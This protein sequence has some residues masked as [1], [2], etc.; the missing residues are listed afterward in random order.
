MFVTYDPRDGSEPRTW[1]F[2]PDEIT[3][4]Q[5]EAIETAMGL[6]GNSPVSF[7]VW[8]S[9]VQ[10][11]N[12][13]ARTVLLWH[14]FRLEHQSLAFKDMPDFVRKQL[15]VEM[16]VAELRALRDQIAKTKMDGQTKEIFEAQ[17]ERD[18]RDAM[19]RETGVIDVDLDQI[20]APGKAN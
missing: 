13:R 8:L 12:M 17:F 3:R 11:G 18:I 1:D 7:E 4:K 15:K 2:D 19:E 20:E 16:S 14:L 9:L 6:V 10:A 5:G